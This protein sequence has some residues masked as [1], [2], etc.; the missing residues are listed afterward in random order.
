MVTL[1]RAWAPPTREKILETLRAADRPMTP[2][3][4]AERLGVL[5]PERRQILERRLAAMERDGQLLPNR[6]GVLLLASRLDF[7]AGRVIG[8]R[9]G[10]GFVRRDESGPDLFLPPPQMDKVMHGDRVL[11]KVAGTDSRGR[12]EAAIVEVTER[13]NRL[14]VGRFLNERGVAIVVPE[15]NRIKHDILI[16]PGHTGGAAHGQ[17]VTCEVIEPPTRQL[18]P[19]GQIREVLG[20]LG[21]P[22]MEIEIAVRKFDVPH[23][24]DAGALAESDAL[25]DQLDDRDVAGRIDLRDVPFITIDGADARDFDDAVYCEPRLSSGKKARRSGFRLLVAIADVSHYV[26]PGSQLDA[27]AAERTTSVYF[28]RRV[29]PMLPEK[30]SNGLCSLN[31]ACDR[32]VMVCDMVVTEAGKVRAYQF[33]EAVIHSAARVTYD[34]AWGFLSGRRQAASERPDA[35]RLLD[36]AA[37]EQR[38]FA[39]ADVFRVLLAA[40][41]E[42]GALEFESTETRIECDQAGR[43]TRIVPVVRNDAHRL[44]EEAM[45]AANVCAADLV[46][47][48]KH[49][50]LYRIHEGPTP[51][52]LAQLKVFLKSTGL[53]L[54]GDDSP[55]PADF[56]DLTRRIAN[57]PDTLLLQTM[58]LRS[59][60]QAIYS[61]DNAGHFGLAYPAYTHFTS[62][63]RRYPD[64]LVHRVI[65]A[66][67]ADERYEPEPL[68]AESGDEPAPAMTRGRRGRAADIGDARGHANRLHERWQA[69]GATCSVNERRADDASRDVQAWLKAQYMRDRVGDEYQGR[70]TGVAPFGVFVTLDA[71]YVEGLVHVSE[72]GSEYFRYNEAGHELRGERTGLRFRLTDAITVQVARVDLEARRIEFRL[73]AG[74]GSV[75]RGNGENPPRKKPRK[76]APAPDAS[77]RDARVARQKGRAKPRKS[78]SRPSSGRSRTPRRGRR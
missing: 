49:P 32:L 70:I 40:R 64:L 59:M 58:I 35:V 34:E 44:I 46:R 23:E 65:K 14:L 26:Q 67:L 48:R 47:R 29:I 16:A 42:R 27:A 13:A 56:A 12:E 31:P 6:K 22:G 66:L 60:Q 11:V 10:F 75:A 1:E 51:E 38:L 41:G 68:P 9:D 33:Y 25:P 71:L 45:L 52:K 57:R 20:D 74:D 3:A 2:D 73:V 18:Q 19:I 8:H 17:V 76:A 39:L 4:L 21:D 43:I 37:L 7:I 78:A 15:D 77:V 28:P 69:I 53:S 36:D 72:L 5:E 55:E 63:I 30:L 62:P 50:C 61:P 24:F 54:G